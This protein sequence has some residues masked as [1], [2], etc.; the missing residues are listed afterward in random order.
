M[1]EKLKSRPKLTRKVTLGPQNQG[2]N[3]TC[4]AHVIARIFCKLIKNLLPDQ[5]VTTE[6]CITFGNERDEDYIKTVDSCHDLNFKN[7]ICLYIYILETIKL[8]FG[9]DGTSITHLILYLVLNYTVIFFKLGDYTQKFQTQ[10]ANELIRTDIDNIARDLLNMFVTKKNTENLNIIILNFDVIKKTHTFLEKTQYNWIMHPEKNLSTFVD[11][12]QSLGLYIGIGVGGNEMQWSRFSRQQL[13][14]WN[15]TNSL[16]K[17]AFNVFVSSAD[18]TEGWIRDKINQNPSLRF[19][20]RINGLEFLKDLFKKS[21]HAMVIREWD[22]EK[23][24]IQILNSW[25]ENWGNNG[26]TVLGSEDYN[27]FNEIELFGIIYDNDDKSKTYISSTSDNPNILGIQN[28]LSVR[29][30]N[31]NSS[32]SFKLLRDSSFTANVYFDLKDRPELLNDFLNENYIEREITGLAL[33]LDII[34]S[35]PI[36]DILLIEANQL[37]KDEGWREIPKNNPRENPEVK[38]RIVY[39]LLCLLT[40]SYFHFGKTSSITEAERIL[41]VS[42]K[43]FGIDINEDDSRLLGE[44]DKKIIK[45]VKEQSWFNEICVELRLESYESFIK[46]FNDVYEDGENKYIS[47][48]KFKQLYEALVGKEVKNEDSF[49]SELK[50]TTLEENEDC[51]DVDYLMFKMYKSKDALSEEF[52]NLKIYFSNILNG[53]DLKEKISK[54]K[55]KLTPGRGGKKHRSTKKRK[56]SRRINKRNCN[57]RSRVKCK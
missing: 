44:D 53:V 25:G 51:I 22:K 10:Y 16:L 12:A 41:K 5:F 8:T 29:G 52:N 20:N 11:I 7:Y 57:K 14:G 13:D 18:K 37:G 4:F 24:E 35:L 21:G 39:R 33:L 6:S 26:T 40:I 43:L 28:I 55:E 49:N 23:G 27:K 32:F 30:D 2:E 34:F 1:S 48:N 42:Y 36:N 56:I 9:C 3:G 54:T 15:Q 19:L 38:L 47:I 31:Y 17:F 50:S 45:F 46:E